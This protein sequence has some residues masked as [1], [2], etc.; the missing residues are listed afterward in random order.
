MRK[1]PSIIVIAVL[2]I[3]L[4]SCKN[5]LKPNY[6]F[7]P[8]MYESVGYE[9]YAESKAFKN[10]QE[11]QLPPK[12]SVKRGFV[13]YEYPNNTAGYD[14]AKANLKTPLDVTTIDQEKA[15]ELFTI[16]CAICHGDK[17]NG[18]GY[19]VEREK[20]LGVP[21]YNTREITEGSTFHVLTYGINTMGNYANQLDQNERW[22]VA[23][24]VMKL[25]SELK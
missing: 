24:Y 25:R 14:A 15:K 8:N 21:A 11:G 3:L 2:S 7:F 4:I 9:T 18:K 13:P 19:L 23:N 17:G 6:E 1:I 5:D 22:M 10:G 12:G 20:I 16:Y